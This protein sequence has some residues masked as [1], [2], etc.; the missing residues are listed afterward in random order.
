MACRARDGGLYCAD[1]SVAGACVVLVRYG[2]IDSDKAQV[3]GLVY[4]KAD[5]RE[6]FIYA[7]S[8]GGCRRRSW[9]ACRARDGGFYCADGA[10]A[11]ACV[12]F[13]WCVAL[14]SYKA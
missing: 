10:V 11:G 4:C 7:P 6:V 13:V 1:G 12:L 9:M 8:D 5:D 14:D 3:L 2:V